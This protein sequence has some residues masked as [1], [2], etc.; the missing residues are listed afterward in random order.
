MGRRK[1]EVPN[2]P[3]NVSVP[4]YLVAAL[5]TLSAAATPL[6]TWRAF[7]TEILELGMHSYKEGNRMAPADLAADPDDDAEVGND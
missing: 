7:I 5:H 4:Q 6:P 3:L 2:A 1:L